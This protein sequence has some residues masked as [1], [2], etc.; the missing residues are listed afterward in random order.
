MIL[1][2]YFFLLKDERLNE[3]NLLNSSESYYIVLSCLSAH[4]SLFY[5][6]GLLFYDAFIFLY[7]RLGVYSAF[8]SS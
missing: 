7:T 2:F 3:E 5:T 8:K 1:Y 6:P 4:D